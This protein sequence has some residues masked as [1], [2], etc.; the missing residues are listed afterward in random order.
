MVEG[1]RIATNCGDGLLGAHACHSWRLEMGRVTS[2]CYAEVRGSRFAHAIFVELQ[3]PTRAGAAE[4]GAG[5]NGGAASAYAN[6]VGVWGTGEGRKPQSNNPRPF[7][8]GSCVDQSDVVTL[9][10][11]SACETFALFVLLGDN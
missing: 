9:D 4:E 5:A 11:T 3:R 6:D 10:L 2:D 1:L 7:L 8:S